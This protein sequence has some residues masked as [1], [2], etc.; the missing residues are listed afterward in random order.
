MSSFH[1]DSIQ[2]NICNTKARFRVS[3]RNAHKMSFP[4]FIPSTVFLS[5]LN[6]RL[7]LM[8]QQSA[9]TLDPTM[10]ALRGEGGKALESLDTPDERETLTANVKIRLNW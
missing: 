1:L 9:Q 2:D 8:I 7:S 6:P 4:F 10:A 3:H 5:E